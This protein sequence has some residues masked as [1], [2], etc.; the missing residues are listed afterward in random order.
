MNK[1]NQCLLGL[2]SLLLFIG[3]GNIIR[4]AVTGETT[5]GD[6][7]VKGDGLSPIDW[8]IVAAYAAG[9]ITLGWYVSQRRQSSTEYFIGSGRMNPILVGISLFATLLS[10]ISYLSMPGESMGKGPARFA[11]L[12]GWPFIYVF[13]VY[14]VLPIYMKKKV[15]SAYEL[16]EE[17]LGLGIR[18]L[19]G[20]MFITLRLV[21]MSLLI[22]LASVALA[23][24]MAIG[25]HWVPLIVLCVG[26]VAVI[27]TSIGG[28]QAVV[29][30]D[31]IQAV[32]L[33]TGAW[34]VIGLV[35]WEFGGL[36]WFPLK[37][38][39]NWDTQP[40]FD[41][42]LSVRV[43]VVGSLLSMTTWYICTAASD[44]TSVQRF[45]ST[46]GVSEA[47]LAYRTQMITD[48]TVGLTMALVGFALLGYFS[49]YPVVGLDLKT[50]ADR[51]FPYFIANVLPAGISGV[52]VAAMFA[53]AMSSIDS[54][55]NSITAVVSRDFVE[56][57]GYRVSSSTNILLAFAIGAVVVVGS[58]LMEYVPG[59]ITEVT[60]RTVNLLVTP[61]FCLFF[62]AMFI[63]F[64]NAKGV[65]CGCLCGIAV[66]VLVGFGG[67]IMGFVAQPALE[68]NLKQVQEAAS[69]YNR[70]STRLT[71]P[72]N[73]TVQ[74]GDRVTL[75]RL[76]QTVVIDFVSS[77]TDKQ[78]DNHLAITIDESVEAMTNQLIV[79][80]QENTYPRFNPTRIPGSESA[81]A[82]EVALD[83]ELAPISQQWIGVFALLANIVVGL[84]A[85]LI[86]RD[87]SD[88]SSIPGSTPTTAG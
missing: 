63:P 59:N 7:L 81:T 42:D 33:F 17:K 30:T 43:T 88:Q 73:D 40:L 34:L 8:G 56:R 45:M 77:P 2:I 57:L 70:H 66:A 26:I 16:L 44:Q 39:D 76:D 29:V 38:Q 25:R 72:G 51:F 65:I 27:Y 1:F 47:R 71:M 61:I 48:I 14:I 52:V 49:K 53:A 22:Y 6:V 21:W 24:M 19:G 41:T 18:L 46:E 5:D 80:L 15:T 58:S 55:V 23:D 50:D 31:L 4:S 85:C 32:L 10:T 75:S 84:I 13:I 11:T 37:W 3:I 87:G 82:I 86:F 74:D 68:V 36:D 69:F 60:Q 12:L 54:G 20:V 28:L 78:E 62:F 9:T 64:A 67:P 83:V 35:T 79:Q